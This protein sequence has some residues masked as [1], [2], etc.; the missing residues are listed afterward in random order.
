MNGTPLQQFLTIALPIMFTI[1]IAAWVN[2]R[3]LSRGF[4][5]VNAA[6]EGIHKRLDL[7]DSLLDRTDP[8][9]KRVET[10]LDNR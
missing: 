10:K 9:L 4:E 1:L 6:I 3:A 2:S 5:G 7:L 8:R